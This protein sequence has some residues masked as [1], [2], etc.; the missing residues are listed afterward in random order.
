LNWRVA[1]RRREPEALLAHAAARAW[2]IPLPERAVLVTGGD[3]DSFPLWYLQLVEGVRPDVAV[4]AAPLLGAD[5]YRAEVATRHGLLPLEAVASRM[6]QGQR[7]R[8]LASLAG[9]H[10]RPVAASVFLDSARRAQLSKAWLFDGATFHARGG[11]PGVTRDAQQAGR[12]SALVPTKVLEREPLDTPDRAP[13]FVARTLRCPSL[14]ARSLRE[15]RVADS[16]DST[17]NFR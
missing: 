11:S 8:A 3:N 17:C 6:S 12:V 2:L 15:T 13:R 10:G 14:V 1:N 4:I 9:R 7:L 16:L 5:W